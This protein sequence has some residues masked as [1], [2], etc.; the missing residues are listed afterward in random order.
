MIKRTLIATA[1]FLV[2]LTLILLLSGADSS[3]HKR[4]EQ[5]EQIAEMAWSSVAKRDNEKAEKLFFL[6]LK[7]QQTAKIWRE[8]ASFYYKTNQYGKTLKVTQ[9][10]RDNYPDDEN[11]IAYYHDGAI[12]ALGPENS[13]G[14]SRINKIIERQEGAVA[15]TG[16]FY[17]RQV[18]RTPISNFP[19]KEMTEQERKEFL[20]WAARSTLSTPLKSQNNGELSAVVHVRSQ[21]LTGPQK[22]AVRSAKQYIQMTGF[23]RQGL[24][25]QL[26]SSAGDK[27]TVGQATYGA[28]QTSACR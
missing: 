20:D 18:N 17:S 23:S 25:D 8:L 11:R 10:I 2:F 3:Y 21:S 24:I 16:K 28:Q 5:A 4:V 7:T 14:Y 9:N 26:S 19:R 6:A 13:K 22:N 12:D 1:K 15:K 27:Y